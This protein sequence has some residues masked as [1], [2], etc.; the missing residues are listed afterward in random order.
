MVTKRSRVSLPI[1]DHL[2]IDLPLENCRASIVKLN[3]FPK[4]RYYSANNTLQSRA[5][6]SMPDAR[7]TEKEYSGRN[8]SADKSSRTVNG[9]PKA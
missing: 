8:I 6:Q 2:V 5:I 9:Y 3:I 7:D 4:G 1:L